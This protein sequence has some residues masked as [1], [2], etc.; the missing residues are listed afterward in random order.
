MRPQK[1]SYAEIL[2]LV[3]RSSIIV[4]SIFLYIEN[5]DFALPSGQ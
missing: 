1:C 5:S 2:S 3:N 4:M